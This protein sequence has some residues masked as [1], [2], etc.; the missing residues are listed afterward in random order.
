MPQPGAIDVSPSAPLV[1]TFTEAMDT[2]TVSVTITPDPGGWTPTW[3]LDG[4]TLTVDHAPLSWSTT[5]TVTVSGADLAGHALLGGTYR[6][7]FA[8]RPYRVYLPV[9]VRM[10]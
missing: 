9:V 10:N 1:I 4:A 2:A 6:W 5:Y 7:T 8:T 3:S